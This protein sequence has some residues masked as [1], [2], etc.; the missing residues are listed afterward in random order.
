MKKYAV[1]ITF[2]HLPC[3][4][5]TQRIEAKSSKKAGDI[6]KRMYKDNIKNLEINE[7]D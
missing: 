2:K 7:I 6:I 1:I 5:K 3:W 4:T